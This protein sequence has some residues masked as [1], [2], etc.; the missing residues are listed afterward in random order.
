MLDELSLL[1]E[2]IKRVAEY[3]DKIKVGLLAILL[4][5]NGIIEKQNLHDFEKLHGKSEVENAKEDLLEEGIIIKISDR[6][7]LNYRAGY[8]TEEWNKAIERCSK[9]LF[10]RGLGVFRNVIKEILSL[11]EGRYALTELCKESADK[12]EISGGTVDYVRSKVGKKYWDKIERQLVSVGLFGPTSSR[13]YFYFI[14][15]PLIDVVLLEGDLLRQVAWVYIAQ[16]IREIPS[17]IGKGVLEDDCKREC[18]DYE[19]LIASRHLRR[20]T[21]HRLQVVKTTDLADSIVK[22]NMKKEIFEHKEEVKRILNKLPSNML[23]WLVTE[24]FTGRECNDGLLVQPSEAGY[25]DYSLWR[26]EVTHFCLLRDKRIL[27]L[28]NEVLDAFVELNL[29]VKGVHYYVATR[30]GELREE[31]YLLAP[32]LLDF[33]HEYWQ[34]KENIL[35]EELEVKHAMFHILEDI[36][37]YKKEKPFELEYLTDMCE[38]Y[39][40]DLQEVSKILDEFVKKGIM[41]KS[42]EGRYRIVDT[43]KYLEEVRSKFFTPLVEYILEEKNGEEAGVKS[44]SEAGG[45]KEVQEVEKGEKGFLITFPPYSDGKVLTFGR[46]R[47]ANKIV[48]GFEEGKELSFDS[49]VYTDLFDINQPHVGSFQQT[50]TGKST[51]AGCVIL[52]VAFQGIP[53]VVFDPK[54]DYVANL[55]PITETI[56]VKRDLEKSIMRRFR[57][58]SQDIRGFDFSKPVTFE[59]DDEE[60]QIEF[61]VYSFDREL[62]G[63]AGCKVLKLPFIVLPSLEE[64]DFRD[65]CNAVATSLANSLPK[66][67]GKGYN[68]ILSKVIQDYKKRN[69]DREFMLYDDVIK[70]LESYRDEAGSKKKER[71]ERLIDSIEEFYTANSYLYASSEKE[72][73]K[74]EDMI[75]NP[76]YEF[77]DKKTVSISIIDVSALPQEKKNPVLLNYVSQVCGRI[78][79][80]VRKNK[81]KRS[82]QLFMVFDEAQNYLPDP[83]DLYNYVRVII[84]RG[85]SLGIKAWVIA[86]SPQSI[87]KEARKQFTTLILSKVNPASVRDEVSKFVQTSGWEDK[88]KRSELGKAL[89]INQQTG[90]VGGKLCVTFTTPQTVNILSNREIA[91][92]IK[93][94]NHTNSARNKTTGK[95]Q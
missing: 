77:G 70:E 92:I 86:Q 52:Q 82:V 51:L 4:S 55:I 27:E 94:L 23:N 88:L 5:N 84:T 78:L 56:K 3:G 47:L 17:T 1:N 22:S 80:F 30:G 28:R 46:G 21:W 93:K 69:P 68:V 71:V 34:P 81:T 38:K 62:E 26:G 53:V 50:R 57:E 44:V 65:Q 76:E 75:K 8:N 18:P 20:G 29:A 59:L 37:R 61:K 2:K 11:P 36:Y 66:A 49:L 45:F 35:P 48:W 67:V 6:I 72:L 25:N 64:K 87:E 33:I 60:R 41:E 89:I 74:M 91:D 12:G 90:E 31:Y 63:V 14:F 13:K 40:V 39:G 24:V 19:L 42:E 9:T 43:N 10:R 16:N 79:N 83:S 95:Q 85:A 15:K 7:K 58:A 73:V 54:P 32:E